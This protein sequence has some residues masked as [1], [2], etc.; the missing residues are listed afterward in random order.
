MYDYLKFESELCDDD[1]F[2]LHI[3]SHSVIEKEW[4]Q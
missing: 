3:A 1:F 4:F 2:F